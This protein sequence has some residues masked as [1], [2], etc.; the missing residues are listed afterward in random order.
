MTT[1]KKATG[2]TT[3]RIAYKAEVI[4]PLEVQMSSLWLEQFDEE[5][6]NQGLCLCAETQDEVHDMALA[7]MISQKKAIARCYNSKEK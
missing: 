7:R 1:H 2:E 3:F 5:K 4:F 6:K